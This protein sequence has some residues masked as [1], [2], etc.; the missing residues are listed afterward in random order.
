[1]KLIEKQYLTGITCCYSGPY[2]SFVMLVPSTKIVQAFSKPKHNYGS[3]ARVV[4]L[5]KRF[6]CFKR[7]Y[8]VGY[9]NKTKHLLED[10]KW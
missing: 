2:K 6:L 3:G 9:Y 8:I 7:Y 5:C 1:M 10:K 4:L